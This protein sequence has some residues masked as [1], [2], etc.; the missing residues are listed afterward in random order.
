LK[1]SIGICAYN[2]ASNIGNLLKNLLNQ[3]LFQQHKILEII[4]V[5]S[6]CTDCT[7]EIVKKYQKKDSRIKLIIQISRQGKSSAQ[8]IILEIANGEVIV[9]ISA[10]VC[11]A[12]GSIMALVDAIKGN[13]GG[14]NS[15]VILLNESNGLVNFISRF[16]WGLHDHALSYE[17]HREVLSHLGGDMFAIKS[18][19][20]NRIPTNVINDD[21]YLGM[22]IR[23]CGYKIQFVPQ[24]IYYAF[25]PK[26]IQDYVTQR[27][28]IIFGHRQLKK[29]FGHLPNIFKTIT[30]LRPWDGLI[31]FLRE[32]KECKLQDL[33]KVVP[34]IFLEAISSILA[35]LDY[36]QNNL[37]QH[38]YWKQII[39]TKIQIIDEDVHN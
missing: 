27:R 19:I 6:G 21:A 16:I 35:Y 11:P 26:T 32:I 7:P 3:P 14:A 37:D 22:T 13:I 10:D 2:E 18:G 8:N 23:L 12:K 33:I 36:H 15:R 30:I 24:A 4:V 28:R 31:I 34:M 25:G 38:I 9:F 20:I 5:C 29:M 39:S 17:S 1:V